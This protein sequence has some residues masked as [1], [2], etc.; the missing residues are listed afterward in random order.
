M[1]LYQKHGENLETEPPTYGCL[2]P[3]WQKQHKDKQLSTEQWSAL[4]QIEQCSI[5]PMNAKSSSHMTA[6]DK[7]TVSLYNAFMQ[8]SKCDKASMA[9]CT[10]SWRN[11]LLS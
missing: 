2:H 9:A 3:R 10:C 8:S 11:C 6:L 5:E 1:L 4:W 7:W